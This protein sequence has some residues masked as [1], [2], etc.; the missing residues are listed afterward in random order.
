MGFN[1]AY[2]KNWLVSWANDK[3]R[4]LGADDIGWNSKKKKKKLKDNL[5]KIYFQLYLKYLQNKTLSY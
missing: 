4:S 2:T 5:V 1:P 3:K